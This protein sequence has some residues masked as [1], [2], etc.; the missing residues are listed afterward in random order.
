MGEF[1]F[2]KLDEEAQKVQTRQWFW[3]AVFLNLL[4]L[5]LTF[6]I[7]VM[8]QVFYDANPFVELLYRHGG[9]P[10]VAIYKMVMVNTLLLLIW[11]GL[12]PG[13][14]GRLLT[15]EG[16]FCSLVVVYAWVVIAEVLFIAATVF[17][18]VFGF[19]LH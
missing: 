4:D 3:V 10:G 5:A 13:Q 18:G 7:S 1:I 19:T 12:R 8:H 2:R 9:W 16:V 11:E 14:E 15:R 17:A 6:L